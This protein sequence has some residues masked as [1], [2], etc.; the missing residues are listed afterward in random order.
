MYPKYFLLAFFLLFSSQSYSSQ[1][2]ERVYAALDIGSGATRITVAQVNSCSNRIEKTLFEDQTPIFFKSQLDASTD[3]RF[4]EQF[5]KL[6][7]KKIKDL[8]KKALVHNPSQVVGGATEAF[9]QAING[10]EFIS[11]LSTT[12]SIPLYILNQ[13]SEAIIGYLS[14]LHKLKT[15][16]Q[17][18]IVWDHGGGSAQ[19]TSL[20][21]DYQYIIGGA[22]LGSET[23]KRMITHV[24]KGQNT[25]T[26]KTPNPIGKV[27]AVYAER[28]AEFYAKEF[29]PKPIIN[30]APTSIVAGIGGIHYWSLKKSLGRKNMDKPYTILEIENAIKKLKYKT[31]R[32]VGGKYAQTD[33]SN[34]ILIKGFMKAMGI[35]QVQAYNINLSHGILTNKRYWHQSTMSSEGP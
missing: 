27:N 16:G 10:Q 1:D 7:L 18:V 23:F 6:T 13:E 35:K 8:I 11:Q 28:F 34:L 25:N 29:L 17:K 15:D 9:R 24:L 22:Q 21:E 14:A 32:E 5:Y 4:S 26:I 20:G 33:V 12:L 19:L 30:K 3:K 31:D 2:C